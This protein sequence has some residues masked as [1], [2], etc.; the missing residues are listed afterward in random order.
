[1]SGRGQRKEPWTGKG[2]RKGSRE[3]LPG[4]ARYPRRHSAGAGDAGSP[5]SRPLQRPGGFSSPLAASLRQARTGDAH[6][7]RCD[8]PH[9]GGI[10]G[11]LTAKD[12]ETPR[13]QATRTCTGMNAPLP[14][15][16]ASRR[17]GP[18]AQLSTKCQDIWGPR[19]SAN[20]AHRGREGLSS[21][22]APRDTLSL[23]KR[24]PASLHP[25]GPC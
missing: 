16:P 4:P 24:K 9:E 3:S 7:H 8:V 13:S 11:H 10:R 18:L 17:L 5:R 2:V 23:S 1:M 20:R 25:E 6:I 15:M 19:R 14:A 12:A 22:A 21:H